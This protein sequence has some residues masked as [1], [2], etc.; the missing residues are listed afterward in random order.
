M[1]RPLRKQILPREPRHALDYHAMR[2]LH[3]AVISLL[4]I[5]VV[6]GT[7]DTPEVHLARG[8][9]TIVLPAS[10]ASSATAAFAITE[11]GHQDYFVA[12]QLT[13]V[14]LS[15]V[16]GGEIASVGATDFKIA[17]VVN[18]RRKIFTQQLFG[19]TINYTDDDPTDI[20]NTR[21]ADDG[22]NPTERQVCLPPYITLAA[23]GIT[24]TIPMTA[25]C[26]VYAKKMP[27]LTGVFDGETQ[28]EW[29]EDA[30][31]TGVRTFAKRFSAT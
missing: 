14:R 4:R 13:N 31:H 19:A 18:V 12:R 10:S 25:Q 8:N 15:D 11:L 22:V 5:Q 26:V 28:L 1:K 3:E 30:G 2:E 17:K 29:I 9:L 20:D 16:T 21:N 24:D 7:G 23:L 27:G 6:N